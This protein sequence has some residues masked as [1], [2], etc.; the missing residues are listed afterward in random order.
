MTH[1]TWGQ[2]WGLWDGAGGRRDKGAMMASIAEA[3]S[4]GYSNAVSSAGAIGCWQEMPFWAG[5]MGWPVSMLYVA[6]YNAVAA[7]HISGNGSNVG[8][9]DVCY[10][11]VSSAANRRNLREPEV[12]SPAWNIWNNTG[13]GAQSTG[14]LDNSG[15]G[16]PSAADMELI[17]KT[18]WANHLQENAI[19]NNTAWVA[20]NRSLHHNGHGTIL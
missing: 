2:L 12:G 3:E 19:P 9:W 7:V 10:N 11:P 17:R 13:G 16:A 5:V 20:Y 14:G 1:Y 18:R 6:H 15:G 4:S 8:A